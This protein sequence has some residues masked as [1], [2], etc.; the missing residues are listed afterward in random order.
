ME[1]NLAPAIALLLSSALLDW[2]L[3]KTLPTGEGLI[4]RRAMNL[5]VILFSGFMVLSF[6]LLSLYQ[7]S[8]CN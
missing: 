5:T 7:S 8:A 2:L 1:D 6:Y 4:T 3:L